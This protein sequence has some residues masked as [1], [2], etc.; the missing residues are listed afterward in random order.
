[1]F[2]NFKKV[3]HSHIAVYNYETSLNK[4]LGTKPCQQGKNIKNNSKKLLFLGVLLE[5]YYPSQLL[6]SCSVSFLK[7]FR[8]GSF[9]VIVGSRST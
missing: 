4:C 6:T 9:Y 5:C 7:R 2:A 3:I 1:M 8:E